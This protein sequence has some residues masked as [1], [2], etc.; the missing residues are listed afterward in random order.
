MKSHL[1][2]LIFLLSGFTAFSQRYYGEWNLNSSGSYIMDGYGVNLGIQKALG[3]TFSSI[4]CDFIFSDVRKKLPDIKYHILTYA[5]E[6]VYTASLSKFNYH[7]FYFNPG[8]GFV[9]GIEQ[10]KARFPQG[11]VQKYSTHFLGGLVLQIQAEIPLSKS[12]SVYL[13]PNGYYRFS[14]LSDKFDFKADFG[15]KIYFPR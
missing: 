3:Y 6:G 2:I 5:F 12:I 7:A 10:C 15:V 4:R 1:L 8:I 13:Q 9:V 14:S 11:I